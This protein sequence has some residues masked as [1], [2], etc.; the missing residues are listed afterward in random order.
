VHFVFDAGP[1]ARLYLADIGTTNLRSIRGEYARRIHAPTLVLAEVCSPWLAAVRHPDPARRI[2]WTQY[3]RLRD[4]F[5][6]DAGNEL[7]RLWEDEGLHGAARN[8]LERSN[9]LFP[10]SHWAILRAHDAYY[11]A[12]AERLAQETGE[13]I[14]FVTN[15]AGAWKG[16]QALGLEAFHAFT[17]DLGIGRL[18]IGNP[19]TGQFLEGRNCNPCRLQGCPSGF[20]V[21]LI[22]LPPN[23]GSATP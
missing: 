7:I 9:R 15:D 12:L 23:L 16:A 10:R 20:L 6:Q 13:R 21:D 5:L 18:H 1:M 2:T 19:S 11:I 3:E 22:G 14:I 17:C 4:R 8:V